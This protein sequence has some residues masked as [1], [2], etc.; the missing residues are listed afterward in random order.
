[1]GC[2]YGLHFLLIQEP[3]QEHF[4]VTKMAL[5]LSIVRAALAVG[6]EYLVPFLVMIYA[7]GSGSLMLRKKLANA[8]NAGYLN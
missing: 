5:T 2:T 8:A 6:T 4:R 3:N 7:Y 1:M